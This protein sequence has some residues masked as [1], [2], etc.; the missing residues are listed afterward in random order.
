MAMT[1]EEKAKAYD[2]A[3]EK[4]EIWQNHLYESG[5]KDYADEL[6]YIFPLLKKRKDERIVA[7]LDSLLHEYYRYTASTIGGVYVEDII[8]WVKNHSQTN[9]NN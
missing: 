7:A 8:S 4:A 2:E 1:M 3:L 9:E 5:D 6:D